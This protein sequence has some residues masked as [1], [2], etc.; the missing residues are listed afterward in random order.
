LREASGASESGLAAAATLA[1]L[2]GVESLRLGVGEELQPVK[3]SDVREL[4]RAARVLEL[5]M[6]ASQSLLKVALE[7]RP[8]RVVLSAQGRESAGG[9]GPIDLRGRDASLTPI[10]RSLEEAGI[11]VTAWVSPELDAVKAAHGLGVIG[12]ELYTGATVDLPRSERGSQLQALGDAAR[13]AAKLRLEIAV[14]GGISF[15]SVGE[16]LAA[17]PVCD[18]VVVGRALVS[19][20][21]LLGLDRAIRDFRSLLL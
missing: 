19:R 14:G 3:E 7:G 5:R 9:S 16:V 12:V 11:P 18:R 21:L 2:A 15:E 1:E 20:A 4:R 17:A 10:L 8:D 6:S 13:L